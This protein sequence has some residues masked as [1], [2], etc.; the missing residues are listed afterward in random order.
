MP[1]DQFQAWRWYRRKN[2]NAGIFGVQLLLARMIA[3]RASTEDKVLTP[4]DVAPWLDIDRAIQKERARLA[5]MPEHMRN[6]SWLEQ[7]QFLKE[8]RSR[9][10]RV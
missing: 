7:E 4:Y 5:S 9:G 6:R 1:A 8:L 3:S 2:P 10:M